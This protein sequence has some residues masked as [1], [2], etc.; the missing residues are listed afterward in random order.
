M[1]LLQSLV[2]SAFAS[3]A[4]M[5]AS[6]SPVSAQLVAY[7]DAGNYLVNANWTNGANQGFGFTPWAI[8]TNGPDFVGVYVA[9]PSTFVIDSVTNVLGTNYTCAWGVYANGPDAINQTTA[10]R[11]FANSLGT[12]TFKLQW[13]SRG[14]GSTTT[15]N[16]GTV[17][18]WCGFTLR[19]GNTT[20]SPSDFQTGAMFYLYYKDGATPSTIYYWDGS[21][22][23]FSFPTSVPNTSFS[24]L[25]RGNITNAIEAEITPGAD[26]VSYHLVLKDCVQNRV[27]FT[28][29]SVF[30]SS[31]TVD[32]AALFCYETTGD[33]I[34]NRMQIT[35]P[36]NIAPTIS[37]LQPADGSLY[38]TAS[39][40]NLS[41]EVDS[42]NSTVAS[43]S[44]KVYLN[45]S[46]LSG[47]AFNSTSPTNQLLATNN[48]ALAPD[49]F[50]T[51]AIVAQDANGNVISNSY[52]FNTFLPTDIYIDASDYNYN[53]GQ[54]INNNTPAN[55]YANLLGTNGVDYLIAD[56]SG[57][58]NTAGYRPGDLVEILTL[59][60]DTTGDPVDHANERAN[61]YTVYNI[62]FTDT[63]NWE[64]YTRNFPTTN[65]S[66]Y[67]RAASVTG[68]QFEIE[69]LAGTTATATNLASIPLGRVNVPNTGGSRVY[70]G[71]LT[72]VTDMFGNTVVV[73][74]S[75]VSTLRDTAL[76]SRVYNLEYLVAVAVSTTNTLRPYISTASPVPGASGL[77][78]TTPISFTIAN[79]QTS[80]VTNTIQLILNTTNVSSGHLLISSNAAGATVTWT[81]TANLPANYTNTA[82]VIYTDSTGSNV[83]N[84]WTFI[85]GT[86]GGVLGNG[87]WSGGGGTNDMFWADGVNWIGGT[88]GPGFNASFASL[89]ATTTLATNN[90]V[91]TNVTI[92]GLYYETNNSGYHTTWIQDGVT[93]TVS[94]NATGT[95]PILQVGAGQN[96]D[97]LFNPGVTNTI[98]G[99]N[100]S[101]YLSGNPLG[102]GLN[103]QLNFQVRQNANP[104]VANAVTL[105][106]SGLGTLVATVGKFTVGQGGTGGNQTN[107]SGRVFLARTNVIT[108]L[109]AVAGQFALGDSSGATNLPGSTLNLGITNAFYFDSMLVGNRR[110][111]NNLMRFNPAFTAV[112]TPSAYI[113]GSNALATSRVT[114][115]T[116]AD[117]STEVF[118]PVNVQ[119]NVDFSG[120]KLDALIG[121]MIVG[122]GATSTADTGAAQGTVT[123]TA[124]TLDAA[125]LQVGVQRA[126]NTATASGIIN[127]NGTGALNSTN[128]ILAQTA[129]GGTPSLVTGTLNVTNG[130]IRANLNAGGGISTVNLN[131]GTL[132]VTN[133]AGTTATPLSALNL[134]TASLHL[135]AD[136]NV[137][138]T[139]M[140]ATAVGASGITTI[141]IDTVANIAGPKTIHLLGYTG[142]D[143]FA[144]LSLAPLPSG[145]SGTLVDNP[146]SID[147]NVNIF[148]PVQPTIRGIRIGSGN[149]IIISGTNNVGST[150]TFSVLST[151]NLLVPITN[152]PVIASG[153]FDTSGNF[154]Y[155]NTA[156]TTNQQEFFILRVP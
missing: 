29:N 7:D 142:A 89:G 2:L 105:D 32:S 26:G 113:R 124:G 17:H 64:N 131:G 90:I 44:V 83:T 30:M 84:S 156:G 15:T 73:P 21:G 10:F 42:F 63:G 1:K 52:T 108:L 23:A 61:G 86:T 66:I 36:T 109:R 78:V 60:T 132:V 96:A 22:G 115:W 153:S 82:T 123:L 95:T 58:N 81:P 91:A 134:S 43:S 34:Y 122:R 31:G 69:K 3:L 116:V 106:M 125:T 59:P 97:I 93:L 8:V 144:S 102:S 85:T 39:A 79:R 14:A 71:Q 98:T 68:G 129:A 92:L 107:V 11:G 67:A 77:F 20:N 74:L 28:T 13:G 35:A 137:T 51:Y 38:L 128:L 47:T 118:F 75:G 16:S 152:W 138:T 146:G 37:N 103:N 40:I 127:V 50:Y 87:L 55:A 80:V 4:V 65:Y 70:T 88:P 148:T 46:L 57:T 133:F 56:T 130:T 136:G 5:F 112:T 117:A 139:N 149:Q 33:Q 48:T 53:Q 27:I 19:T 54:F 104:P 141:T 76:A 120:G 126:A 100:G 114:S 150:G 99:N 9:A 45:G 110:A 24:D 143:P 151:N 155:T 121:T 111:T 49:T 62:G 25:G 101:L 41:F 12:N 18:G 145:Y 94:N 140:V 154:S 135:R 72:P 6:I 119:A 147:L